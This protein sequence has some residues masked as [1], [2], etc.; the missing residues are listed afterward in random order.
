MSPVDRMRLAEIFTD[1]EELED[2][3]SEGIEDICARLHDIHGAVTAGDGASVGEYAHR[4]RGVAANLGA[5]RIA[6]A[7]EAVEMAAR[8]GNVDQPLVSALEDAVD[9]LCDD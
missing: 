3:I 9:R 5:E 2:V 4:I 6:A 8:S 7:A 1:P